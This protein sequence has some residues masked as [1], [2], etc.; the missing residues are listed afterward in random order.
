MLCALHPY[1]YPAC[2]SLDELGLLLSIREKVVDVIDTICCRYMLI[3]TVSMLECCSLLADLLAYQL[4]ERC[5]AV[6]LCKSD[7][8]IGICVRQCCLPSLCR[9][10][11]VKNSLNHFWFLLCISFVY[12]GMGHDAF[13]LCCT[14]HNQDRKLLRVR[15]LVKRRS[16]FIGYV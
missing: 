5:Y 13:F 2:I 10:F 4:S 15:E 3:V 1:R 11:L 14:K 9:R 12:V 8:T 7:N 6:L 16:V